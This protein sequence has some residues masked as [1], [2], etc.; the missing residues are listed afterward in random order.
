ML[1]SYVMAFTIFF[2]SVDAV[3]QFNNFKL[4]RLTVE[5]GLSYG[6]INCIT[7]DDQGMMW[8]GTL[9]GLNRYDGYTFTV[10]KNINGDST[11]LSHNNVKCLYKDHAGNIWIG[12]HNGGLNRYNPETDDFKHYSRQRGNPNSL[13]E[14]LV[15][16]IFESKVNGQYTLWVSTLEAIHRYRPQTDDFV[17][18]FPEGLP[19]KYKT[20]NNWTAGITQD[21]QGRLWIG[22]WH[23]GL[24]YFD[25]ETDQF[26]RYQIKP[27]FASRFKIKNINRILLSRE[28]GADIFW[29]A[30]YRYGF[31]KINLKNGQVKNFLPHP[32]NPGDTGKNS[33]FA[34]RFKDKTSKRVIWLSTPDGLHSFDTVSEKFIPFKDRDKNSDILKTMSA[35]SLFR[36]QSGILWVGTNNGIV[37]LISNPS[38]FQTIFPHRLCTHSI[39]QDAVVALC[40]TTVEGQRYLWIGLSSAGLVRYNLS[41]GAVI[42]LKTDPQNPK[43]LTSS[44]ITAIIEQKSTPPNYLWVATR[45]GLNR[46]DQKTLRIKRYF[47]NDQDPDVSNFIWSITEDRFSRIFIGT[48]SSQLFVFNPQSE[49]IKRFGSGI[50]TIYSLFIDSSGNL[51]I[52]SQAGLKKMNPNTGRFKMFRHHA[53]DPTSISIGGVGAI[54]EDR[55]KVLWVGTTSGLNRFDRKSGTFS[56][57]SEKDGLPN[58]VIC[59]ILEDDNGNLWISTAKGISKFDPVR[60]TFKNYDAGDGLQADQFSSRSAFKNSNGELFF[61]GVKGITRFHPRNIRHNTRIPSVFLTDFQIY[62]K[63]MRPGKNSVLKKPIS[64]T[65]AITLTHDQSVFSFEFAAID[66]QN[67]QKNKYAYKMEGVDPDWVQTD[68]R[69]RFA[70]Y[71]NLDPGDYIFRVKGSNNDGVWN[72]AGTALKI[73]ILPPWWKTRW[74]FLSYFLLFALLLY[75]ARQYDMKRQRLRQELAM[76]H[77]QVEKLNEMDRMKSR[78]FANISHEFRTPLTLIKGPIQQIINGEFTGNLKEQCKM[79]LRNSD[80]LLELI[81]QILDLSKLESGDVKLEVAEMDIIAFLKGI[82]FSFSSLAERRDIALTF[83]SRKAQII[84]YVDGEKLEKIVTNLLSN[85]F[86][87]TP[88]GGTIEMIVSIS[89]SKI[90]WLKIVLS[91]SGPGIPADQVGKIFNRFYQIDEHYHKDHEGS[92]IG[93]SLTRELVEIHRGAISVKSVPDQTTSFQVELPI[94]KDFFT[95]TEITQHVSLPA[96]H[97]TGKSNFK[98]GSTAIK[99]MEAGQEAPLVLIVEDNPEV[100]SFIC[101]FLEDRYRIISANDGQQ[102][103]QMALDRFPD[104]II[105][106]VMMPEMDGFELCRAIK[107]DERISHI[108]IILLTAKADVSSK[109]EGLEYGAD[110]YVT[111]PFEARELQVRCQNLIEQRRKLCEKFARHPH[112]SMAEIAA[113]SMDQRFLDRFLNEFEKHMANPNLST[114]QI[115]RAVGMSRSNLNRKIKALTNQSTHEFIRTLRLKHAARLLK[116]SV[117]SVAEVAYRVGF[118]NTSH[119]AKV[120]RQMFGLSPSEFLSNCE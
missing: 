89:R 17:R 71:T 73:T 45:N 117:G 51:W 30:T 69:R 97:L 115:A 65:S 21:S 63:S 84:G 88:D 13:Q 109:I 112:I 39:K 31:Y 60:K 81:N 78:F 22:T 10:Y 96:P 53:N 59:A 5:H 41:T 91:N 2:F 106:D 34:I 116:Q 50:F 111:K 82:V 110:A 47:I 8:F 87:F 74:A 108:P 28:N 95:E 7:Q 11:S 4:E 92:G 16:S 26:Y 56:H 64:K 54:Y 38:N 33:I 40:E 101:S 118:N 79:I 72:E 103:Q 104:L 42:H 119:F 14:N 6:V 3:A 93:L 100:T 80:R 12:T 15:V 70:T 67:P 68:A 58:D 75:S 9:N 37:K 105:S 29:I 23:E 62:N 83:K 27:E 113:T 18:Y 35:T 99:K 20:N 24:F 32:S 86:K 90:G 107:S 76:E 43:S 57:F 19:F 94:D 66:Y 61:G 48:Q 55:S 77:F 49:T 102:G 46:I 52:G 114:E 1:K 25:L 85:A 36:D 44:R 120:F 98:P